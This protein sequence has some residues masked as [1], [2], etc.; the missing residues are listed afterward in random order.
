VRRAPIVLACLAAACSRAPP[1]APAAARRRFVEIVEALP[2]VE[3]EER[4]WP[5]PDALA[6]DERAAARAR[7][8]GQVRAELADLAAKLGPAVDARPAIEAADELVGCAACGPEHAARCEA[9]RARIDE[10]L[11]AI[12]KAGL[13]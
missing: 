3:A 1:D 12:G 4:A 8:I 5:R 9:A 7:E 13:R 2:R 11:A 6:C 10:A